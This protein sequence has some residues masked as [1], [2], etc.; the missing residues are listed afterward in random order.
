MIALFG[1]VGGGALRLAPEVLKYF[2]ARAERAHE[3]K[4]QEIQLEFTKVLGQ[5]RVP[6]KTLDD[7]DMAVLASRF[8][9]RTEEVADGQWPWVAAASAL[10]RPAVTWWLVALYSVVK[11]ASLASGHLSYDDNDLAMLNGVLTFWFLNRT[12]TK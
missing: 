8:V 2:D 1:A 10:V 5:T 9:D 7:V 3:L 4:M 6:E 11:I 12:L